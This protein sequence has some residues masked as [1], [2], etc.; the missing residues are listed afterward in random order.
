MP[1]ILV[2]D[3]EPDVA[4]Y[5][6]RVLGRMGWESE[7]AADGVEAVLKVIERKWGCLL[8]D[9][10]MPKLDGLSALRIIRQLAPDIPVVMITGHAAEA[11]IAA[12]IR[13]G[14]F[15]CLAKPVSPTDLAAAIGQA[16]GDA[17]SLVGT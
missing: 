13:V 16:T 8:M 14:A 9:I 5:L 1:N 12:S 2:V 7:T 10:V 3:D 11:D 17:S 6:A 4:R 15:A